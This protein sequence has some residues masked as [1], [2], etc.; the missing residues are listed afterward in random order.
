MKDLIPPT[1]NLNG[2]SAQTLIDQYCDASEAVK[3]AIAELI[4]AI[5]H[6]RDYP[7]FEI[8][9]AREAFNDRI[10]VLQQIA[11]DLED[12]AL[13]VHQQHQTRNRKF[14]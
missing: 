8:G 10:R 2:T 12:V 6:G 7:P 9:P 1:L 3:T 4:R 5:P 11:T 14:G 13:S